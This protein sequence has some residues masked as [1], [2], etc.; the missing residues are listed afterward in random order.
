MKRACNEQ[1]VKIHLSYSPLSSSHVHIKPG[2]RLSTLI[3]LALNL[4]AAD[5]FLN[6]VFLLLYIYK[7]NF[8]DY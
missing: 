4:W 2:D 1:S 8:H 3:P 7:I 6:Y 5:L